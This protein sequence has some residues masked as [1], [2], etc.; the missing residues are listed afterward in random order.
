MTTASHAHRYAPVP[1]RFGL[2]AMG[3]A[4]LAH[5]LLIAA[6]T[7]GTSW[8]SQP[9]IT[10]AAAELWAELPQQAAPPLPLEAMPAA[11]AAPVPSEPA[12]AIVLEK[13]IPKLDK[14][15]ALKKKAQEEADERERERLHQEN[16]MR[17]LRS[18]NSTNKSSP[19]ASG[20]ATQNAAPSSEYEALI[21]SLIAPNITYAN[22][23]F[24]KLPLVTEVSFRI[25]P[26]GTIIA[27]VVAKS[28]GNKEWD[29]VAV[30]AVEKTGLIPRDK[31]GYRPNDMVLVIRPK[32]KR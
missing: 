7:W 24:D 11:E 14:K 2:A 19:A 3:M 30:R 1:E 29:S 28:S 27:P 25:A 20:V 23:D 16:I 21:K 5:G 12:P 8:R 10:T 31:K 32:D 6:L 26:D 18:A 15:L 9:S 4:F 17:S 13:T 22:A